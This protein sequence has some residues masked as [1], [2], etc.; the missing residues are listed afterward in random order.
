MLERV[1]SIPTKLHEKLTIS[2]IKITYRVNVI[3]MF[4]T[5]HDTREFEKGIEYL[6]FLNDIDL[7]SDVKGV[8][9]SYLPYENKD[10]LVETLKG[11][12]YY[13][14]FIEKHIHHYEPHYYIHEE[15]HW[16]TKKKMAECLVVN[17]NLHG[18]CVRFNELHPEYNLEDEMAEIYDEVENEIEMFINDEPFPILHNLEDVTEYRNGYKHGECKWYSNGQITKE[19]YYK[20]GKLH[21]AYKY[22]DFNKKFRIECIFDNGELHGIYRMWNS[23]DLLRLE[24]HYVG[25]KR[26]GVERYYY[27]GNVEQE[28]IYKLGEEVES[29]CWYSNGILWSEIA[30]GLNRQWYNNGQIRE[31]S[32][33]KNRK[34]LYGES[35]KWYKNGNRNIHMYKGEE[36]YEYY[37]EW[38]IDGN[39]LIKVILQEGNIKELYQRPKEDGL[40]EVPS[41]YEF[42]RILHKLLHSDS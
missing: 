25:G 34:D 18:T 21:G 32:E 10:V 37:Y 23:K 13:E 30:D 4:S 20:N 2:Y 35:M 38:D 36:Y 41:E 27:N 24:R 33:W 12:K 26:D 22:W 19:C 17:G 6:Y 28:I 42:R 14:G 5:D 16:L 8:I 40:I 3:K 9:L 7:I 31:I 29:R 15:Y 1:L 11:D 39:L